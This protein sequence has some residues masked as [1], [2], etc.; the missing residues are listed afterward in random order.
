MR[1]DNF[2]NRVD[3]TSNDCWDWLGV[4]NQFGYGRVW[5]AQG[6]TKVAHRMA[7]ELVKGPIRDGFNLDH[8]CRNRGCVNPSHL[9]PVTQLENVN[10][11][12]KGV[13]LTRTT[14]CKRGHDLSVEGLYYHPSGTNTC[15]GCDR[16]RNRR[17]QGNKNK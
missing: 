14:H 8:L 7:W 5:L 11:G 16:E 12:L 15:R 10:R 4:K 2:W 17:R 3:K 9:E 6:G 1:I 13:N